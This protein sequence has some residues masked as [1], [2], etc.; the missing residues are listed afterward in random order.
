MA[1]RRPKPLAIHQLNGN[2]R[3][4]SQ[5]DLHGQDNP[6][7]ELTVPE[8]PKGMSKSA[9]REWNR[10]VP[11]LQE[12]RLLSKIDGLALAAY[13]DAHGM[14]EE[15]TKEI[16][17]HGMLFTEMY[18]DKNKEEMVAGDLKANPAIAIKFQ[19]LK[20]MKSF[21]IEFGLTPASRSKLK[22]TKKEDGDIM[23][24]FLKGKKPAG[25]PLM[26]PAKVD[27]NDM[28]PE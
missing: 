20:V 4:F 24:Q 23:E 28:E 9:R 1:G 27:P 7:P 14:V 15:S 11:L 13:C 16:R 3:H 18:W 12:L 2:P 10:I 25:A 6:Q 19:A 22:V 17:K 5:A 26:V 21:L 8:M